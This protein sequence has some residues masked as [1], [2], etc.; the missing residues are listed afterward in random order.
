MKTFQLALAACLSVPFAA[1]A[2]TTPVTCTAATLTGTRSL[3]L[4]GRDVS[5]SLI[6]TKTTQ[7][8]G[9]A[10]FDGIGQVSFNLTTNTNLAQGTSQTWS[11]TYTLAAN[12]VGT[13][14]IV[15]GDAANFTLI[16]YNSGKNFTITGQDGTYALTGSGATQPALCA[17]SSL[18]GQ[19]LFSGNG[20][21]LSSGSLTGVNSISGL[22]QFDGRGTVSGTWSVSVNGSSASATV[23]GQYSVTAGCTA[24]GTVTDT[25]GAAYSLAFVVSSADAASFTVDIG[26][27]AAEFSAAGHSAFTNPGQALASAA[28]GLA[29]STPPGSIFALYGNGLATSSFQPNNVPLPTTA[30]TTTVTVNGEAV[31][32]FYVSPGQVNAQMP[33]DVQPGLATVVVNVGSTTSNAAAF[34]VPATAVPG[35]FLYGNNRAVVQNSD[36]SLNSSTSPAKVGSVVVAYLTGGGPVTAAGP[37]ITGHASPN[38]LSPVTESISITVAGVAAIV[39]YVG[40]TP[41]QVGLYQANFVVPQVAAGDRTMVISVG[42]TPSAGALISVSN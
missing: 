42:G 34:T 3:A 22:L 12:C 18:S 23:S 19:Y 38:G 11:G 32:L 13:V 8:V 2:Q 27:L 30:L 9:T 31:P 39:N 21:G 10:T 14:I 37:W 15:T 40:L 41:T 5:S 20:F 1:T 28:S 25:S 29:S 4:T 17:T 35:I 26:A 6:F 16:A 7:S 33:L 36:F 24:S